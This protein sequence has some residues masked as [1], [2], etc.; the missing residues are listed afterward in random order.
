M[1]NEIQYRGYLI[2]HGII[3]ERH[4]AQ[5]YRSARLVTER[6]YGTSLAE[7]VE[8]AKAWVDETTRSAAARRRVV[9]L[10]TDYEIRV[11]A[12]DEYV[13]YFGR[14]NLPESH[15]LALIGHAAA[16][17]HTMSAGQIAECAGWKT[18][19]ATNVQ[20]GTLG[21]NIAHDLEM[22]LPFRNNGEQIGTCA[23]A[24]S[25]DPDWKNVDGNFR[26]I[27]HEE[28]VEALR[29]CNMSASR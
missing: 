10:G 9:N 29:I 7:I 26:W 18:Y 15:R 4:A 25:A 24:T 3:R 8:A 17:Q 5:V 27:M 1:S 11:P 21:A 16:P 14:N 12:V 22:K 23:L 28:V 19:S 20:Y 2:R 6:F 13:G